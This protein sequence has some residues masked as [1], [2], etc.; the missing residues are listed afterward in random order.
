MSEEAKDDKADDERP[1]KARGWPTEREDRR[2]RR[3][4]TPPILEDASPWQEDA[5]RALEDG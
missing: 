5:I 3:L 2:W 1:R 4:E